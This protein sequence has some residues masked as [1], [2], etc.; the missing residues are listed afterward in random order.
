MLKAKGTA[1]KHY[2]LFDKAVT[3][4]YELTMGYELKYG[5]CYTHI[6]EFNKFN[7]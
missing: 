4:L 3:Q 2:T 1:P 7:N 6:L 5:N